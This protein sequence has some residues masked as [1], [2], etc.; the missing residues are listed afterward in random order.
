MAGGRPGVD[1]WVSLDGFGKKFTRYSLPTIHN[2]L[3]TSGGHAEWKYCEPF[4]Q[5]A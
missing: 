4:L 5:V 3:A 1:L 2:Q